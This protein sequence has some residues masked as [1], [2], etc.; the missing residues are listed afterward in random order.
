[1]LECSTSCAN[2]LG[3]SDDQGGPSK[4]TAFLSVTAASRRIA[5]SHFNCY[6]V[7]KSRQRCPRGPPA[8]GTRRAVL[9][10]DGWLR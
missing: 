2:A 3:H 7:P 10:V 8:V 9:A 4:L 1:M 6:T 5:S